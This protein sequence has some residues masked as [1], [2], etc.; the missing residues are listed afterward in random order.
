MLWLINIIWNKFEFLLWNMKLLNFIKNSWTLRLSIIFFNI[1]INNYKLNWHL[2]WVDYV[3]G[4]W[5]DSSMNLIPTK[6]L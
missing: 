1:I 2:V 3:N 4:I 5:I 6:H